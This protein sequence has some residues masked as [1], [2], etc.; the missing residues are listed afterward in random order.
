MTDVN[1]PIEQ[2]KHIIP[3]IYEIWRAAELI[4]LDAQY[5]DM[6]EI[7]GG[8]VQYQAKNAS[9]PARGM[10]FDIEEAKNALTIKWVAGASKYKTMIYF[11]GP[12]PEG[13]TVEIVLS[14]LKNIFDQYGLICAEISGIVR[15][16]MPAIVAHK[17]FGHFSAVMGYG[18]QSLLAGTS[19]T[20]DSIADV[21]KTYKGIIDEVIP[22]RDVVN[23]LFKELVAESN[24]VIDI[25]NS[26][27]NGWKYSRSSNGIKIKTPSGVLHEV[28]FRHFIHLA[29]KEPM[30]CINLAAM[31]KSV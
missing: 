13:D 31:F 18:L 24:A 7:E 29:A 22:G 9:W 5:N 14:I 2:T 8:L 26:I 23:P 1:V 30:F 11:D 17:D 4:L 27:S 19:P 10:L 20:G 6:V 3:N 28:N 25:L 21:A 12:L 16:I 15:L